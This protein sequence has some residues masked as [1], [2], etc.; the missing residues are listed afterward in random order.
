RDGDVVELS[1]EQFHWLLEGIDLAA[2]RKHPER[3]YARA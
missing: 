3:R 1:V 2:M